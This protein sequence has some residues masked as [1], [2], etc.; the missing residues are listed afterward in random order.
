[1]TAPKYQAIHAH[2]I[3]TI[4]LKDGVGSVTLLAGSFLGSNG[5]A[6]T[7]TPITVMIATLN[8]NKKFDF[9]IDKGYNTIIFSKKGKINICDNKTINDSQ[10]ALLS[11]E[12][13]RILLEGL[14]DENIVLILAGEPINEEIAAR[15]PF[16]MNTNQ[17]L[18]Q[19]MYD[20]SSGVLGK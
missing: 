10:V 18:Q 5:P 17:E 14:D 13:E 19:A 12:H 3:P 1:M 6:S 20:Y 7:F 8:K 11:I 15:G 9:E 4:E 16:V 2:D